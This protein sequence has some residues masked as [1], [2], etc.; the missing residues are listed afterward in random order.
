MGAIV[1]TPSGPIEGASSGGVQVFRG[2]PYAQPPVGG[3]RFRAPVPVPPWSEVRSARR[4]GKA[5][6]RQMSRSLYFQRQ[7]ELVSPL[8]EII[9]SFGMA[10]ALVYVYVAEIH[11]SKFL[12]DI[13][14]RDV[15]IF[16]HVMQHRR[17]QGLVV[18]LQVIEDFGDG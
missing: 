8:I 17:G 7:R 10:A 3:L 1:T 13:L 15:G 9:G 2:V 4:F 11:F 14:Q 5:A 18:Q 6:N 12:A 16:D